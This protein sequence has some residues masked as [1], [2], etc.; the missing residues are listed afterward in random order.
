MKITDNLKYKLIGNIRQFK[1]LTVEDYNSNDVIILSYNFLNNK[2]YLKFIEDNPTN[3]ILIHNYNWNRV[4]LDEGHE[5]LCSSK[6]KPINEIKATL[7]NIKSKYRW[8][9]SGT[10]YNNII[11]FRIILNYISNLDMN[12]ENLVLYRH[13]YKDILNFAFRKNT[14]LS[15][16]E[17]V[18]IPEPIITTEFLNMSPIERTIY[19]SA[20]GNTDLQIELCNHIMVSDTH[21]SVLGNKPLSLDEIETKM[22]EYYTKKKELLESKIEKRNKSIDE[23]T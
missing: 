9:C 6:K 18:A 17:E 23:I 2:N 19:D 11:S 14:K 20:L 12:Q 4:I 5:Y 16:T 21:L 22:T 7:F 10:P 13:I 3:D 15:V 1:K 8:I